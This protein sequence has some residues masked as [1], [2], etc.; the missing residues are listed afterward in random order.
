MAGTIILRELRVRSAF[1]GAAVGLSVLGC[2]ADDELPRQ[3]ISGQ[4]KL[5]DKLLPKGIVHFYPRGPV[6][7]R[8]A[9]VGGAMIRNGRF[10]IP[11]DL[12]LIPGNYRVAVFA[13]V[14][15][16][17]RNDKDKGPGKG[18]TAEKEIIPPKYNSQSELEIEVKDS[19]LIKELTINVYSGS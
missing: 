6:G 17:K 14:T 12:G 16:D 1:L 10:S 3:S 2:S 7:S 18:R 8:P 9:V 5:D 19:H 4:I 11:H 13:S 15:N